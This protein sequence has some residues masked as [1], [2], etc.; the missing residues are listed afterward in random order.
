MVVRTPEPNYVSVAA[1]YQQYD[2]ACAAQR[3]RGNQPPSEHAL[4]A[5]RMSENLRAMSAL[6][7]NDPAG[8]VLLD[9]SDAHHSELVCYRDGRLHHLMH[10][11]GGSKRDYRP[12]AVFGVALLLALYFY[13]YLF[14]VPAI[15]YVT[16]GLMAAAT[17]AVGLLRCMT[18]VATRAIAPT[19]LATHIL[20]QAIIATDERILTMRPSVEKPRT[21]ARVGQRLDMTA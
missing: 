18:P 2:A 9:L 16:L 14:H 5:A 6:G 13:L 1:V 7:L 8:I 17:G 12:G 3:Q 4:L 20:R 19:Q 11:V 21:P 15:V 10:P